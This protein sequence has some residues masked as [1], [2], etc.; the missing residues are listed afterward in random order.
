LAF[1]KS[2]KNAPYVLPLV[3]FALGLMAKPMLVTLAFYAAAA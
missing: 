1:V 2:K 3:F